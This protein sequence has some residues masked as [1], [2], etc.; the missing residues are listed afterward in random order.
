MKPLE[1]LQL[2]NSGKACCGTLPER[3]TPAETAEQAARLE[4]AFVNGSV[5]TPIGPVPRISHALDPADRRGTIKARW[6]IGRMNYRIEPGLY[7]LGQ[8]VSESP[9]LVTANYKMTFDSLRSSVENLEAW[10]LVL[11]TEG[12]NVWCAAGKG[13][14]GTAELVGRIESSRLPE[15]VSHKTLIVP[16]LGAPGVAAHLV[17]AQSGFRVVY[18]PVRA[19]DLET[20]LKNKYKATP[21]MRAKTFT[22]KERA[23]LVP[24]ELVTALKWTAL[25]SLA[26]FPLFWR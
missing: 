3:V 4:Q 25:I 14:F 2:T 19:S 18:G 7:A 17:R 5:D 24:V 16:Q 21:Q 6:G 1:D 15:V 26:V 9:V 11:D 10:I 13:T 22:F 23:V 20:F 8:P 12:I